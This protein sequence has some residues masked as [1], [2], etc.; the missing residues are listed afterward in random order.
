MKEALL[1][2]NDRVSEI[3]SFSFPRP[4]GEARWFAAYTQANHEK[5]VA[6]QLG[7]RCIE[8][9]LP[10][11][12]SVRR[13]K[14]RRMRLQVPLVPGYVFVHIPLEQRFEVLQVRSVVRLVG[15]NGYPAALPDDEIETLRRGLAQRLQAEPHPYLK[16]GRR[17]HIRSGPLQGLEGVLVN[18]KGR[19]RVVLSIELILRS[20]AVEVDVADLAFPP[21]DIHGLTQLSRKS[22]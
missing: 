14:D 3:G 8:Q 22:I 4:S 17:V 16:V 9:F 19:S 18:R 5:R 7:D 13:W 10:T 6:E 2:A 12:E 20:I 15:F 21:P 1:L 11:Y